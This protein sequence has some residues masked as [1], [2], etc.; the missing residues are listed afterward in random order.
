MI[1]AGIVGWPEDLR[2]RAFS[3]RAGAP[4]PFWT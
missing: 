1:S 3:I 2:Y 4:V